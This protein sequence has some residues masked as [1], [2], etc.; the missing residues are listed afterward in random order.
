VSAPAWPYTDTLDL[1][2]RPTPAQ[3][4]ALEDFLNELML[5]S[6]KYGMLID[7]YGDFETPVIRDVAK[8]TIVGLHLAYFVDPHEPS[9]ILSYDCSGASI[10]DG[11]WLVDTSDG[12]KELRDVDGRAMRVRKRAQRGVPKA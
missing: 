12:P 6:R 5:I 2:N 7:S 8:G 9:T 3:Q 4:E 1:E 10:L 11:V